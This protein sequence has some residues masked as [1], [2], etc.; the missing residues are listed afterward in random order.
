MLDAIFHF[1]KQPACIALWRRGFGPL[2]RW[3]TPAHRRA[4]LALGAVII[5]FTSPLKEFRRAGKWLEFTPDTAGQLLAIMTL[6]LLVLACYGA[7]RRF[8]TLPIWVRRHP[9][10]SL[11]ACFWIWMLVAWNIVPASVTLRT[12][13]AGCALFFP[14]LLW[15]LGYLL[16]TAQRGKLA[17][18]ALRDHWFYL[19]PV[20]G[21]ASAAP[22]GKGYDYLSSCEARDE[23]ALARTQ[24]SG[25][26]LLLLALICGLGVDL[27]DGLV[28]GD[29]NFFRRA[30]GG[31]TLDVAST[32]KMIKHPDTA[33]PLWKGWVA[34]Y[35]EL[36]RQV[37]VRCSKG[38]VIIACLRFGGFYVFRNT[39]KPLAAETILEFWNRYY[40][41]FKELLVN[42]FFFPVYTRYFKQ[43]PR[44]RIA[45][46]VFA[47]A[48][49]GNMYYHIIASPAF[50]HGDWTRLWAEFN[51]RLLYCLVLALG[52]YLSMLREKW[53]PKGGPP[54][55]W[56]RR[57]LAIFGVWTF[58]A[59]IHL[60][61]KDS[62]THA[63][64][65][66]FVLELIGLG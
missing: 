13:L 19:W 14:L 40:Y 55:S 65:F 66:H 56:P 28:F 42:F 47:S 1:H 45:A 37:L 21:N 2:L 61:A 51:P 64:R 35:C 22:Y 33:A 23:D 48:F 59:F 54:R 49:V 10:L 31:F 25:L 6:I 12:V 34:I 15:R 26:K 17:G 44:L 46:A 29:D 58:F 3:L 7:A 63:A 60:W 53:R 5:A 27:L 24:L 38:H 16:F 11:H 39:Y 32:G 8:A 18:T 20:W 36:F 41:Y 62:Y 50:A 30:L 52:I 9:Q 57:A 4:V 43:S